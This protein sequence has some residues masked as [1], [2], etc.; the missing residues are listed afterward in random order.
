[1]VD[2]QFLMRFRSIIIE[3]LNCL[4]DTLGL[5][6]TI[7]PKAERRRIHKLVIDGLTKL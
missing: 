1:M 4:D 7:P 3:L 2:R 6:R 5:P